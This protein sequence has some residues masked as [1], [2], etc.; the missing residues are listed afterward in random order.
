M[1]QL[2]GRIPE[3]SILTD[4]CWEIILREILTHMK[5]YLDIETKVLIEQTL[6]GTTREAKE[7]F[8]SYL[9]RKVTKSRDLSATLGYSKISCKSCGAPCEHKVEIPEIIWAHILERGAHLTDEQRDR[10]NIWDS[11]AK[12]SERL[13]ELLLR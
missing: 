13:T 3:E 8:A 11:S 1:K 12:T 6:Y 9:T 2:S 4:E 10:M 5:P 7:T